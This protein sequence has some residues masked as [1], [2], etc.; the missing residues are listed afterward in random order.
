MS[1][2]IIQMPSVERLNLLK[3]LTIQLG[4]SIVSPTKRIVGA[5]A[6]ELPFVNLSVSSLSKDWDSQE[7]DDW[8]IILSKMSA[9]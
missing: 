5:R 7:D 3:E 1:E 8:D 2:L 9:L 4:G 6:K